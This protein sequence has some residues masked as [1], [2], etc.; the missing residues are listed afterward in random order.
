MKDIMLY[1]PVIGT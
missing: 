1:R